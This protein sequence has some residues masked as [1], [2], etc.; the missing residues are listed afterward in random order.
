MRRFSGLLIGDMSKSNMLLQVLFF[1]LQLCAITVSQSLANNFFAK[2]NTNAGIVT[3]IN[4]KG[5]NLLADYLKERVNRFMHHGE[6]TF[7]FSAPLTDEVTFG[8]ISTKAIKYDSEIFKSQLVT[9][10]GQGLLWTGSNLNLSIGTFFK[11][12]T[13]ND[14]FYGSAT[15]QIKNAK[16]RSYFAAAINFDGHLRTDLQKCSLSLGNIVMNFSEADPLLLSNYYSQIDQFIGERIEMIICSSFNTELVPIISNRL[17]NTPMSG[18]LFDRYF[19]NYG[20]IEHVQYL[21]NA[22]ELKHR[23]NVFGIAKQSKKRFNDFRLPFSSPQIKIS[24]QEENQAMLEF[25][26]SN[27]SISTLLYWMDQH[28][29][30]DFDISKKSISD[31]MVGYLRTECSAEDICAGTLFPALSA[32]YPDGMVAIKSH[33]TTY[34]RVRLEKTGGVIVLWSQVDSFVQQHESTHRFL[35]ASMMVEFKLEKVKF[36]NYSI[37]SQLRVQKFKVF[38]VASLVEGIDAISLEFLVTALSEIIFGDNVTKK[39][40]GG[41]KLPILFDFAQ[42][43]VDI[44]FDT[45][46]IRIA[47]DFCFDQGCDSDEG[48][49]NKDFDY[50]DSINNSSSSQP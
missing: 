38:D 14:E 39:L 13:S 29:K 19:L 50:Y 41:L 27:Y 23:G 6:I 11:F 45:D 15:L 31:S 17:L 43:S 47:V 4:Q 30:F 9:I 32:E 36:H 49:E 46:K 1:E 25:T 34:P 42:K 48:K 10:P 44:I 24:N 8:L 33:T 35:T 37:T 26:M 5:L 7:N 16:V 22:I 28:Q 12:S 21:Q 3:R 2:P 18:A 40:F 20:L